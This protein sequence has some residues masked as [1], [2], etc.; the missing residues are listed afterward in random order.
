MASARII[1]FGKNK[2]KTLS[3]C[4]EKYLKWLT[5]HEKVLAKRN[6]WACRDAKYIL[7]QRAQVTT[8]SESKGNANW[9]EWRAS[10]QIVAKPISNDVGLRGHLNTSKAFSLMR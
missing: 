5:T 2:G 1:D 9:N 7:D 3:E 4:D 6:R 10:L 8:P